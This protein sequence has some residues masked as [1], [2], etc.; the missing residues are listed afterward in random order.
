MIKVDFKKKYKELY[1]PSSKEFVIID[2]PKMTF[3]MVDGKGDPNTAKEYKDAIAV[4]YGVSYPIKMTLKK[5]EKPKGYYDYVVPP[6]EGL[7]W[8]E[9]EGFDYK[10]KDNW[11]WTMMIRIPGFVTEKYFKKIVG[12]LKE[13]KDL[14][15]IDKLRYQEFY[16][17][18]AVQIMH[19]GPFSEE[20]PT[21]QKMHKFAYDQGYKLR[22]KHHEIYISDFRK[23][24]PEKMKSVLRHPV[25]KK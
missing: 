17:G 13:K 21:I 16:E 9:G 25:E 24:K 19:I 3:L 8:S 15:S 10:N 20:G 2:I 14:A 11:L 5:E 18:L 7:W 4:L 1:Q 22:D 23:V 12:N 6:L